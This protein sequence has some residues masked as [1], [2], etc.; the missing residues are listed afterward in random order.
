MKLTL[1][2]KIEILRD[3]VRQYKAIINDPA[4]GLRI[5]RGE[6]ND[7]QLTIIASAIR[8]AEHKQPRDVKTDISGA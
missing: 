8:V 5:L 6:L 2:K 3:H 4:V 7:A 1:E